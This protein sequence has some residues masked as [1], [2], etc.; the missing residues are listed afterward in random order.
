MTATLFK[1]LVGISVALATLALPL[2]SQAQETDAPPLDQSFSIQ[3]F[4]PALGTDPLITT[5]SVRNGGHLAFTAGLVLGYQH[6]PFSIFTCRPGTGGEGQPE[7]ELDR[8]G[9]SVRQVVRSHLQADLMASL[10]F[11]QMFQVGLVLPVLLYQ[12]GDGLGDVGGTSMDLGG[13]A[14]LGDLR[15]HL[16][17]T[18]PFG[19]GAGAED[20][21][22]LAIAPT[23]SFPTGN[24]LSKDSYMGDGLVTVHGQLL[25]EFRLAALQIG[26]RL[27]Y[28]WREPSQLFSTELGHEL[29]Y[30]VG[31]GYRIPLSQPGY[32][33]KPMVEL[34]GANGFTVQLDESPLE[35]DVALQ[36][37]VGMH[38]VLLAGLGAGLVS[39]VGVPQVRAFAG[40]R[41][42]PKRF[43]RDGD[44][45]DDDDDQCPNDREDRDE[46]QDSDGCP[47][48]DND[49]DGLPDDRDGC[50]NEAED[51]DEYQDDDGCP[52]PDNDGDGIQDGYDGC[53]ND[54]EDLDGFEDRD[55][56]PDL[57]HDRDN[58]AV[59]QD[60]CPLEME[61]TDGFADADGCPETDVDVD[62]IIDE[63]DTCPEQAED[64]D[65]YQDGDGCPE[66]DNDGDFVL[67][68]ADRCGRSP[69][70]WNGIAD[71]DGCPERTSALITIEGD[72]L[73]PQAAIAFEDNGDA[74]RGAVVR[75][76]L[77]IIAAML[78]GA[79]QVWLRVVS[80]TRGE[81][82][83]QTNA[84]L[85][86]RRG[87][88]VR[89]YLVDKG[90][91][92]GRL[93]VE[94]SAAEGS[95]G[96]RQT[97]QFFFSTEEPLD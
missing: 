41:Y 64:F 10:S 22:G 8:D 54:A 43:D 93:R 73:V 70:T 33:L 67:D 26:A 96:A 59:P 1:K 72:R 21:F 57:D 38:Y 18:A 46:Y 61:D 60:H 48:P 74:L 53:P 65:D 4:E 30:A 90:I 95:S 20:G 88:A 51:I 5:E 7:C 27:G 24:A 84:T 47:D 19:I 29:T 23:I 31:A 82:D 50:V 40:F 66:P 58:I 6:N 12:A 42:A 11:L 52:E 77:D 81:A 62:G 92:T 16:K 79:P 63:D 85:A 89:R 34:F 35:L 80:Q 32:S 14:G 71:N 76:E 45:I 25:A 49:S 56:C 55:G 39:A 28:R 83:A 17:W 44:G 36:A 87:E 78:A 13:T 3:L 97:T 9:D 68:D 69:E 94:S 91:A 86:G 15:L 37:Q 75:Q 2:A